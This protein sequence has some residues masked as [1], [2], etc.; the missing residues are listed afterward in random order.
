MIN[1][2][3]IILTYQNNDKNYDVFFLTCVYDV[4]YHLVKFQLKTPHIHE[5]IKRQIVFG[6]N[7]NQNA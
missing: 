1:L 5:E 6:G 3:L 4:Y 7:L 2:L